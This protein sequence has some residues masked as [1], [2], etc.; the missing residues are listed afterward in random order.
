MRL[1]TYDRMR[2]IALLQRFYRTSLQLG[3][4]PSVLGGAA[5]RSRIHPRSPRTFEDAVVFVCDVDRCLRSLEP[6]DQCLIAFC[7]LE[8]RSE[9]EAACR[10]RCPQSEVSRRLGYVL[11]LLHETFCRLGLLS[12]S[13]VEQVAEPTTASKEESRKRQSPNRRHG[14]GKVE[15]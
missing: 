7:V 13:P 8:D 9:W 4:M 5:F 2:S 15:R 10:F 6:F 11:D 12:P 1:A 14:A 3:R